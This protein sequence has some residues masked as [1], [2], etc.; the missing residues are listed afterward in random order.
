[1]KQKF[2]FIL[3]LLNPLILFAQKDSVENALLWEISGKD[4]KK[5]SYIFGTIHVVPQSDFFFNEKMKELFTSTKELIMETD[6]EITPEI[7]MQMMQNMMLPEGKS[8]SNYMEKEDYDKYMIYLKDSLKVSALNMFL[9]PKIKPLFSFSLILQEKL[10]HPVSYEI[11][12][13][14][15]AKQNKMNISGL[16]SLQEQMDII[17]S[18]PIQEQI[19]LLIDSSNYETDVMK[20]YYEMLEIYKS[21][22]INKLHDL[23]NDEKLIQKYS[24][25]L[26]NNRNKYWLSLIEEKIK[27]YPCFI[28]VG[29]GHLAGDDG[30]ILLLRKIG[31]RVEPVDITDK[32]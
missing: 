16:E 32:K 8:L 31:Y 7:Q 19:N 30:L 15:L 11:Y 5:A 27:Q 12:F 18:I 2:L 25:R 21:Q 20:G 14:K 1:M 23:T 24:A 22:K 4:V 6:M 3:I 28:A 10:E 9:L 29:A 17:N 13:Q 26:I